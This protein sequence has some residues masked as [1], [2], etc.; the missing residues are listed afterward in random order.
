MT[1]RRDFLKGL[2]AGLALSAVDPWEALAAPT[3]GKPLL[4]AV[5][6]TGGNDALNT[7]VP[8]RS[9]EYRSARPNLA[10]S[11]K[12]LL[13]TNNDLALHP[14]LARLH[15]RWEKGQALLVPGV[16]REDHDRSHFRSSD[17]LH[18]AGNP[19]GD[20]WMAQLG[21]RLKTTP[22]SFGSTVSRAVA[23]PDR[24]PVGLVG[25]EPP[26]FPGSDSVRRAW[27]EMYRDWTPT[28][29]AALKLK[30]SA[31]IVEEVSAHLDGKMSKV[32]VR[33]PFAKDEFG[34]RFELAYRLVASGFPA[35]VIH[36]SAGKFDTHSG[37]LS[38]HANQLAQF[39]RACDVFFMNMT[40]LDRQVNLLAYSEFGRRVAENY[41]GGTDH[42]AGG[43]AWMVGDTVDGGIVGEYDLSSLRD[44]DLP[45]VVHYKELY[46]QAVTSTFGKSH[47]KA[48]FGKT[49]L[50]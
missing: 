27:F 5:H 44:G 48:L 50:G 28:H 21:K 40:A 4:V 10:L 32:K 18:G 9:A 1:T 23:C 17:I 41:S 13:S 22:L 42:G 3:R 24:P 19:G 39:D 47:S 26:T 34:K 12:G 45:T 15:A 2:L 43:L 14:S 20:G 37:Q 25:D 29:Q 38:P 7:L 36:L 6:L 8:H 11:S 33:H 49:R 46:A 30:K 35:Q 31:Q 16:G